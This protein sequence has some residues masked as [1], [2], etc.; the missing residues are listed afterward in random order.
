[1]LAAREAAKAA[2][3]EQQQA[4]AMGGGSSTDL[5]G[6]MMV[7]KKR[8]QKDEQED[9]GGAG[10]YS[11]PLQHHWELK[12]PEWINDI[13][14]EIMDGKNILDFVDPEIDQKLAEL[15]AEEE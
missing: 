2:A 15:E 13:I 10:V 11:L 1:M 4:A 12:K 8:T 3:G 9:H 5:P 7:D 14:P 6:G